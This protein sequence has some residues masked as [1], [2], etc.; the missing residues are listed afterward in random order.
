MKICYVNPTILLKR[1][2]A[3]LSKRLVRD[4]NNDIAIFMPKKLFRQTD[5]SSH[6]SD[7]KNVKIYSYSTINLPLSSEWPIPI[8]PMFFINLTRVFFRYKIIHVWVCFYLSSII[9]LLLGKLCWNR[10]TI[11]TMDTIPGYSFKMPGKIMNIAMQVYGSWG[12]FF[13]FWLPD[14]I[15][16]YGQ[17]LIKYAQKIH[18]PL[19]KTIVLPTGIDLEKM[20][21]SHKDVRKE[22]GIKKDEL[23]I[24]FVGLVVPRKGIDIIISV[25]NRLK[26]KKIKMVIVGDGP[27]RKRYEKIVKEKGLKDK[28][29]FVGHRKD[30]KD[31]YASADIF[32]FPSRGEGLAGVIMEAMAFKLPVLTSNIP[33]TPDLI[34]DNITGILC[35]SSNISQFKYGLKKLIDNTPLRKKFQEKAIKHINKFNWKTILPKYLKIYADLLNLKPHTQKTRSK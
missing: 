11:L 24:L 16:V 17:S 31:F 4:K 26:D 6:F 33:C 27:D 29:I 14:T 2:I 8:T 30:V 9:A 3:E 34:I 5:K 19:K 32:F 13:I 20:Q 12:G 18:A 15:T 21:G 1:P 28:I 22:L 35:E 7:I 23:M 25:I 10:K